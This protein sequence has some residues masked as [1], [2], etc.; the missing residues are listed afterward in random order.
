MLLLEI[1]PATQDDIENISELL[2]DLSERFITGDFSSEGKQTL[3]ETLT[4]E[5]IEKSMQSGFRYHVAEED[6]QLV[7][8]VGMKEN[9]HLYHLFVAEGFQRRGIARKLWQVAMKECLEKGNPGEF[10]VNSSSY[11]QGAYEK[12]GFVSVSG[13]ME[14]GGVV[15]FP[16]KLI[17]TRQQ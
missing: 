16:M 3:L 2:C 10:T 9:S 5:G 6:D 15:F 11:A 8:V 17:I 4:P 14:K 13:P 1:R 7:G 12:L